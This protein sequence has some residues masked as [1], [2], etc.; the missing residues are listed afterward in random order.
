MNDEDLIQLALDARSRAYTPYSHFR[1]GAALLAG[2]GKVYTGCNIENA[3]FSPTI[4]AERVAIGSA[5]AAGEQPC[6]FTTIAIAADNSEPTTPCGVCR[7]VLFELAPGLRVIM[8]AAPELGEGK[9][10]MTIEELLP[11]G[12]RSFDGQG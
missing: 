12:F 1:V 9:L 8:V 6:S 7:Q 4:C 2:N 10:E 11:R 3:A 5:I